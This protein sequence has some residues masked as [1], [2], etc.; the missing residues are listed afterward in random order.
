MEYSLS[1][2]FNTSTNK[3]TTFVVNNVKPD[4][5][6]EQIAGLMDLIIQKNIFLTANGSYTEK[7]KAVITQ[8][9]SSELN[10]KI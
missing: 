8:K 4:V 3:S 9:A 7:D 1:L 6:R 2:T 5:T 10:M